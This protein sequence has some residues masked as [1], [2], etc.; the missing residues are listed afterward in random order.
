MD[1]EMV[2]IGLWQKGRHFSI[3]TQKSVADK[4]AEIEAENP[5]IWEDREFDL[6]QEAHRRVDE[7][8]QQ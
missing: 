4:M 5:E 8:N 1:E 7:E 3:R 6:L 2:S